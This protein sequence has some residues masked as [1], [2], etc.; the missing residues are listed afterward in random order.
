MGFL[1]Y[2]YGYYGKRNYSVISRNSWVNTDDFESENLTLS[3]QAKEEMGEDSRKLPHQRKG[4]L[5]DFQELYEVVTLEEVAK[6]KLGVNSTDYNNLRNPPA[7]M[8]QDRKNRKLKVPESHRESTDVA[9]M[10][11]NERK[12]GA[13][14]LRECFEEEANE[15]AEA[16]DTA[17][18]CL[19]VKEPTAKSPPIKEEP[20]AIEAEAT[21]VRTEVEVEVEE[22][23]DESARTPQYVGSKRKSPDSETEQPFQQVRRRSNESN[24]VKEASSQM[25]TPAQ[26]I[27]LMDEFGPEDFVLN[28]SFSM[29]ERSVEQ[30]FKKWNPHFSD[31]F[32]FDVKS[33]KWVPKLG[34]EKELQRREKLRD[35][36]R[37]RLARELR[38][39]ITPI[40]KK[41]IESTSAESPKLEQKKEWQTES[42]C[43]VNDVTEGGRERPDQEK[44]KQTESTSV[45]T[46][47]VD[48]LTNV[49]SQGKE[50]EPYETLAIVSTEGPGRR[51][52][53]DTVPARNTQ[54]N[55]S[56]SQSTG[57]AA[58]GAGSA[59][60]PAANLA[61]DKKSTEPISESTGGSNRDVGEEASSRNPRKEEQT[62]ESSLECQRGTMEGS[63]DNRRHDAESQEAENMESRKERMPHGTTASENINLKKKN[64][65][66]R[67]EQPRR[68]NELVGVVK[69]VFSEATVQVRPDLPVI[70]EA[71]WGAQDSES[72]ET[73]M[74]WL[75]EIVEQSGQQQRQEIVGAF[76]GMFTVI[77]AMKQCPN[78]GSIQALSCSILSRLVP[79]L[80]DVSK[81]AARRYGWVEK[82]AT[83][84]EG[85]RH[86]ASVVVSA[87]EALSSFEGSTEHFPSLAIKSIV[88]GMES[89]LADHKIQI[90]GA[91]LLQCLVARSNCMKEAVIEARGFVVMAEAMTR[92]HKQ[93]EKLD[94]DVT[95]G[96]FHF[97]F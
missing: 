70:L 34:K 8:P 72:L 18:E 44:E 6:L 27:D 60:K 88:S 13:V 84:L 66:S 53:T 19:G 37:R 40:I 91:R 1:V 16:T 33:S 89:N 32:G 29:T 17:T 81:N 71:I 39:P 2:W 47:G 25:P 58:A 73:H 82:I 78:S 28:R 41:E 83:A 90:T 93:G 43:K 50:K 86:D 97:S 14:L 35:E 45:V 76:G 92:H 54:T 12:P 15:R 42:E 31:C 62:N 63:L 36:R 10:V 7:E 94:I 49:E 59:R 69:D 77:H 56:N 75:L 46:G 79:G 20:R 96:P 5:V 61:K 23:E 3:G 64:F 87:M 67:T 80:R 21:F 55:E 38:K 4:G 85:H 57:G 74:N 9:L 51:K 52:K 48:A 26:M 68:S 95:C 30:R 24:V 11:V 22:D 65:D